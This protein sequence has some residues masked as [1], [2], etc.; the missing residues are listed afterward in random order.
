M[1]SFYFIHFSFSLARN[2]SAATCLF[3]TISIPNDLLLNNIADVKTKF[4]IPDPISHITESSFMPYSM[5]VCNTLIIDPNVK[6]AYVNEE[7]DSETKLSSTYFTSLRSRGA[8]LFD[9]DP[10]TTYFIS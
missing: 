4:P 10:F 1:L 8:L 2:F 5:N 9:E 6:L 7:L 3:Y